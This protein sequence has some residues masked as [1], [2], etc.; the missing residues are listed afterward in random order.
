[1]IE[2]K[3]EWGKW[4]PEPV[5]YTRTARLEGGEIRVCEV[6]GEAQFRNF[7]ATL[8]PAVITPAIGLYGAH[9][10]EGGAIGI[11]QRPLSEKNNPGEWELPGGAARAEIFSKAKD[12][13]IISETLKILFKEK[14]GLEIEVDPMPEMRPAVLGGGGD[15]GFVIPVIAYR[16][17]PTGKM[18]YVSPRGADELADGPVGDRILSGR[19]RMF[20]LIL[21]GI[22]YFSPNQQ[23]RQE[24]LQMLPQR[25]S[26]Q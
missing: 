17:K 12:E 24:A 21:A 26:I 4:T 19:K 11:R 23:Y 8:R 16:G 14:I 22:A 5:L 1:M 10:D 9:F 2:H 25:Y 20:Q 15:I 18:K 3:H 7:T 6:C 13:R